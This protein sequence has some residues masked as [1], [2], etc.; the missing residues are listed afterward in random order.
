[1]RRDADAEEARGDGADVFGD[2]AIG[3]GLA[4]I[5]EPQTAAWT[6]SQGQ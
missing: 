3:E 4:L 6:R 1:M 2:A 5:V